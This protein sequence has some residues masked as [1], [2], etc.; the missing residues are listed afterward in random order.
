[1]IEVLELGGVPSERPYRRDSG[2]AFKYH[3]G[4]SDPTDPD[5]YTPIDDIIRDATADQSARVFFGLG[6]T[7]L[8]IIKKVPNAGYNVLTI[9]AAY[10]RLLASTGKPKSL[11]LTN[12]LPDVR[13]YAAAAHKVAKSRITAELFYAK[14]IAIPFY[15]AAAVEY[16]QAYDAMNLATAKA[17]LTKADM[18]YAKGKLAETGTPIVK[19]KAT[20]P[21][22]A[23]REDIFT[24]PSTK[25]LGMDMKT[26]GIAA[27]A[28]VGIYLL[29]R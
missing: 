5:F 12:T 13:N 10:M 15:V 23:D 22:V 3:L 14:P 18:S 7:P 17:L 27:A 8:D 2:A 4:E 20:K 11:A 6:E 19:P 24:P 21:A 25:I 26:A 28:L 9:V 1:M 29:T 16:A